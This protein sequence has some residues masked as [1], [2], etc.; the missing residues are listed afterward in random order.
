MTKSR[1][2]ALSNGKNRRAAA[3]KIEA[4]CA[5]L[6]AIARANGFDFLAYLLDLAEEEAAA[7]QRENG[8]N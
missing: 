4:K 8:K 3:A 5:H 7:R 2:D 6:K 1:N